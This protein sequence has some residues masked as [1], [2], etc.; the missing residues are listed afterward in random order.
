MLVSHTIFSAL[1]GPLV[2][3]TYL[4][5]KYT[6]RIVYSNTIHVVIVY[7]KYSDYISVKH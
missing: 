7:Q 4:E 2:S 1:V 3:T 5:Q 6:S